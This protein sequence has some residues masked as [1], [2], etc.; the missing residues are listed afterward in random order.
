MY[1]IRRI[2]GVVLFVLTAG[3]V[4][5]QA[6]LKTLDKVVAVVGSAVVLES[7]V[8]QQYAKYIVDGGKEDPAIKCYILQQLLTQKTLSQQAVIDSVIVSEDDVDD[9]IN[10]NMRNAISRMGGQDKLE[11]FIGRSILQYKDEIKPVMREQM[12]A[13]KMQRKITEKVAVTPLEVKRYLESIPKDSL[14]TFG[15]EVEIG[16]LV[17]YPKLT[18]SEKQVA[19]D[20]LEA[21]RKR[22]VDGEQF[23]TLAAAYSQDGSAIEGGDLGF[24]D[25]GGYVKEFAAMAFKLKV[26]DLSPVFETEY[27]FHIL[28]V[29]ERQGEQVRVSHILIKADAPPESLARVKAH[30]DSIYNDVVTKKM[31]F[32]AAASLYSDDEETKYNGGMM[33]NADNVRA[34]TTS[35]PVDR[36][37]A[38]IFS[39]IDTLKPGKL[40]KPVLFTSQDGKQGYRF[41]I[42]KAKTDPHKASFETDFP[43]IKEVALEDKV[44]RTLSEWFEKR[45]KTIY[46]KISPD[47]ESCPGLQ[48]WNVTKN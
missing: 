27:G 23:A 14:P 16:Q 7:D 2:T 47:F 5:A 9:R 45:R 28:K 10:L 41:F 4:L 30:A 18:K 12:V 1:M 22:I 24:K 32:S 40:S 26:G 36:L 33:L 46:T 17:F 6:P 15:A 35:I 43:K 20:K 8:E 38:A 37:D 39:A 29:T 11:S 21:I 34:R 31:P 25:R 44:N 13:E 48:V 3:Q 19:Y 42:L